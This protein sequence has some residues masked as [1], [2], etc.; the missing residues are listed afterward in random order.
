MLTLGLLNDG[1]P[2]GELDLMLQV[3][4][5]LPAG[6]ESAPIAQAG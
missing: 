4:D 6:F 3:L 2:T 5:T 1:E